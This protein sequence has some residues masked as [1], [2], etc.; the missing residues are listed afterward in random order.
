MRQVPYPKPRA[1]AGFWE[2]APRPGGTHLYFRALANLSIPGPRAGARA[3]ALLRKVN[4]KYR[5]GPHSTLAGFLPQQ[6][7][8]PPH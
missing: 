2:A 8:R 5:W 4:K 1:T 7:E 3:A 6:L